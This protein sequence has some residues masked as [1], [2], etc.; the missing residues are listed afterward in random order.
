[1]V[2]FR[3]N[4]ARN[5]RV[6][7]GI[8]AEEEEEQGPP[9][10]HLPVQLQDLLGEMI[11]INGMATELGIRVRDHERRPIKRNRRGQVVEKPTC[12][13]MDDTE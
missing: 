10:I 8:K 11:T 1:M 2:V 6:D 13:W 4:K 5:R 7:R 12:K 3:R 9:G